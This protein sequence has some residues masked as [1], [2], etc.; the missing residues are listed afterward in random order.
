MK[1][2][3][4]PG[5]PGDAGVAAGALRGGEGLRGGRTAG[6]AGALWGAHGGLR[7]FIYHYGWQKA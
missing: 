2:S 5:R 7:I 1:D 6:L 4:R 3:Q